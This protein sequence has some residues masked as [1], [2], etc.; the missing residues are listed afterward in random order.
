METRK[1]KEGQLCKRGECGEDK[2]GE[3]WRRLRG[4]NGKG[5]EI[6]KIGRGHEGKG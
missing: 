3:D 4:P 6:R 5:E 2:G 1:G